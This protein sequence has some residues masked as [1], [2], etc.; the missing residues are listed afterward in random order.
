VDRFL[1]HVLLLWLH[2]ICSILAA[3]SK[4]NPSGS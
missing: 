2:A 4:E 3:S 1:G